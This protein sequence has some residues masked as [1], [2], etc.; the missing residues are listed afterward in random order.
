MDVTLGWQRWLYSRFSSNLTKIKWIE[1]FFHWIVISYPVVGEK[2]SYIQSLKWKFEFTGSNQTLE[3]IYIYISIKIK[4][5]KL[6][7]LNKVLL[8]LGRRTGANGEDCIYII[9]SLKILS[10]CEWGLK[11]GIKQGSLSLSL[12][13]CWIYINFIF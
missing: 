13:L 5:E 12:I 4:T 3:F 2:Q 8:V 9:R 7:C 11:T 10:L 1:D 6:T